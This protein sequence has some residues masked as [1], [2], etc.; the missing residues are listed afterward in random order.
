MAISSRAGAN[1]T[2][3]AMDGAAASIALLK[4]AA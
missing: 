3:I 1:L 2:A 4:N